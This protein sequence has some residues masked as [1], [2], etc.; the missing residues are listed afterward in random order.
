MPSLN[1]FNLFSLPS[2]TEQVNALQTL[3]YPL[4]LKCTHCVLKLNFMKTFFLQSDSLLAACCKWGWITNLQTHQSHHCTDFRQVCIYRSNQS[5][6]QNAQYY[7]SMT[8]WRI[9]HPSNLPKLQNCRIATVVSST[10]ARWKVLK[11]IG[12]CVSCTHFI[13]VWFPPFKDLVSSFQRCG[14]PF[15]KVW[16]PLSKSMVSSFQRLANQNIAER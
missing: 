13:L 6:I 1:S 5:T 11:I 16:C 8:A 2:S 10:L 7:N 4:I 14:V 3:S 15:P 9:I 12:V